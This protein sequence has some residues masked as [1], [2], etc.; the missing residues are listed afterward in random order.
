V[1]YTDDG[2]PSIIS[3]N[4]PAATTDASITVPNSEYWRLIACSF[5]LTVNTTA[6]TRTPVLQ[7]DNGAGVTI[8]N[9][10]S[11][12][13]MPAAASSTQLTRYCYSYGLSGWN[14]AGL[15]YASGGLGPL[16]MIPGQKITIHIDN[17]QTG[18]QLSAI[19][20]QV[21]QVPVDVPDGPQG[22]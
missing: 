20:L 4:N 14:E 21:S 16:E 3:V 1:G 12:Y 17:M 19:E 18:D 5:S 2:C 9:A 7:V 11:G 22:E 13:G 6:G 10:V 15:N 8:L